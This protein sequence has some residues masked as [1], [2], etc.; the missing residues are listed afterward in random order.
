MK[1]TTPVGAD[2]SFMIDRTDTTLDLSY[3]SRELIRKKV[4]RAFRG[5]ENSCGGGGHVRQVGSVE[6]GVE[7]CFRDDVIGNN[8][9]QYIWC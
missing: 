9:M 8:I 6:C 7:D 4:R 5:K 1:F 3:I 2:Q